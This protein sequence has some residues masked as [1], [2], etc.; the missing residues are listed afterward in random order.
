MY[1]LRRI[2]VAR[3]LLLSVATIA[4]GVSATAI[5][6]ALGSGA[7]PPAKPLA[8]AV[9]DALAGAKS[10]NSV[11]GYSASVKL[12]NHLVEGAQLATGGDGQTGA[13]ALTSSPL[14]NGASGR[15]WVSADGR[16]RL[17]LQAEK[18]DTQIVYDGQTV[19]MY[20]ASS[21]TLYRYTPK[22][23]GS[24]D[25]AKAAEPTGTGHEVPSVAKIEETLA[26]ARKHAKLSEA[27][28]A[29]VAGQPAYTVRVS[30]NESGSL[31]GGAELSF[32]A[33]NGLP[34]RTAVYSST[35]SAP[36]IELAASEVSYGPVSSSVFTITPPAGAKVEDLTLPSKSA[37][38][39]SAK[40]DSASK[41]D[42]TT[43]GHGITSIGVLKAKSS[44]K[45]S[46]SSTE[47][48]PKVKIGSATASELRT[49]LGT[50]L[51]FERGGVRYVLAG[52]VQPAAVEALARG[53]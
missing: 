21:N 31:I 39:N 22:N 5:A 8:Q 16:M 17:E 46:S 18:G 51:T 26:E 43:S 41:P 2:S 37:G 6:L 45:S 53:L 34:L 7:K 48:L 40:P 52:A 33:A 15:L 12:T 1:L 38:A 19:T 11:Q 42:V 32:D 47:N 13:G 44:G 49:E 35:S 23:E 27:T 10:G 20:D 30:P 3:L 25:K 24:G 14:L 29:N 50:I 9:H 36:V 4:I 28:P